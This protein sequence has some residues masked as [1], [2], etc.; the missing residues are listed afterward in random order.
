MLNGKRICVVMPA[1]NAERTFEKT[2][3]EIPK[4]IVDTIILVDDASRDDTAHLSKKLGIRTLIHDTN[5]GYGGNQ[6]TCYRQALASGAD[7]VVMVHP[8]Y[9]Y[10]PLL[11]AVIS[12][13]IAY[14]VYDVVLASRILG[15]T[16]L[17]NGMPFINTSRTVFSRSYR[18]CLCGRRPRN[19]ILDIAPMRARYSSTFR[20]KTIRTI[21][22]STMRSSRRY[23]RVDSPSVR[24]PA[25]QNIFRRPVPSISDE[26][27]YTVSALLVLHCDISSAILVS[28]SRSLTTLC[29][30]YEDPC[31]P[32][33][34]SKKKGI[35]L[36]NTISGLIRP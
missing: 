19:T 29:R 31:R 30:M 26:V 14:G 17:R 18:T 28:I 15:G 22:S 3:T 5:K 1:Y 8:D 25:R 36:S 7:I 6:K 33:P 24:Y 20:L 10:T 35:S 9:Q 13:M 11:I 16:S 12:S 23:S 2:F 34:K 27:S 32:H 4:D 21:S